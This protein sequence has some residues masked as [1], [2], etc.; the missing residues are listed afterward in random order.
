MKTD[1][2]KQEIEKIVDEYQISHKGSEQCKCI[3]G[4]RGHLIAKLMTLVDRIRED[5]RREDQKKCIR[6]VRNYWQTLKEH[7]MSEK[8]LIIE[9]NNFINP[10]TTK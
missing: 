8:Q 4:A 3:S 6:W 2:I 10:L 7:G 1:D 9:F 5:E